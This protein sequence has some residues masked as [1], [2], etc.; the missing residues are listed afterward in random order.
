MGCSGAVQIEKDDDYDKWGIQI[1]VA[2]RDGD[3]L[4][5]LTGQRQSGGVSYSNLAGSY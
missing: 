4:I 3:P 1:L 2:F 5:P